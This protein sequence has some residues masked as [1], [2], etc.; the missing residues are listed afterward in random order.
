[1]SFINA[2]SFFSFTL[3][4]ILSITNFYQDLYLWRLEVLAYLESDLA[5]AEGIFGQNP[6]MISVF[7]DSVVTLKGR[8]I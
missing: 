7:L 5:T 6:L 8:Q 1:M 3:S 2:A 4:F